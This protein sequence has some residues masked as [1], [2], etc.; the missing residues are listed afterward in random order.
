MP[1]VDRNVQIKVMD[2]K[3]RSILIDSSLQ[4]RQFQ[5]LLIININ[6]IYRINKE[7]PK[8]KNDYNL[9]L[10]PNIV[11]AIVAGQS[12]GKERNRM[13]YL[14]EQYGDLPLFVAMLEAAKGLLPKNIYYT[15]K[16]L[17]TAYK[18][19]FSKQRSGQQTGFPRTKKLR[20]S[21]DQMDLPVDSE[22]FSFK[23][24]G[25]LGIN[26][27]GGMHYFSINTETL[28]K[29][30]GDLANI[31]SLEILCKHG[32]VYFSFRYKKEI[33][34][35]DTADLPPKSAGMD[36]GVNN[37]ASIFIDDPSTPSI[38]FKS[39]R[40]IEANSIF[41]KRLS[42]LRS[43]NDLAK[44]QA[45]KEKNE[46]VSSLDKAEASDAKEAVYY[47]EETL[48]Y[49]SPEYDAKISEYKNISGE[50]SQLFAKRG[51][52]F[53]DNLK[54]LARRLLEILQENEVTTL[55]TSRN[56][57]KII[58]NMGKV[59]NQK[60]VSLPIMKFLDYIKLNA[61]EYGIELVDDL[62]EAHTSRSS[63]FSDESDLFLAQ[64]LGK[65]KRALMATKKG[66][67]TDK[68]EHKLQEIGRK[69]INACGGRRISRSC[70][71]GGARNGAGKIWLADLGAALNHIRLGHGPAYDTSWVRARM[72]KLC[73]P[74]VI[75]CEGSFL[76]FGLAA[77]S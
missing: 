10:N 25:S 24:E 4:T 8:R 12:G 2:E 48:R 65:E 49:L 62:D 23:Q 69:L 17:A 38:V 27:G 43:Q 41:N 16:K 55:Y 66:E 14:L 64:K 59:N 5:N 9:L 42:S 60:F 11:R 30:V 31:K 72:F 36:L 37:I 18:S 1:K 73:R 22:R 33:T 70:Y 44:A 68:D 71:R 75:Q 52:W 56:L 67:R 50:I 76:D 47:S 19:A 34:L 6:A 53:K 13:L 20:D 26:L 40:M 7:N 61:A 29:F 3:D 15:V 32:D 35:P 51:H 28:T 77:F 58:P 57:G 54:K 74:R 39:D 21:L 46:L 63:C 45:E